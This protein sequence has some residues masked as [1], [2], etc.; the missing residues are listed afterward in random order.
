MIV[1]A[2]AELRKIDPESVAEHVAKNFEDFFGIKLN[3]TD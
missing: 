2:M 3:L 1:N